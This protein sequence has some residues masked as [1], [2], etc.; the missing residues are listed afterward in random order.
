MIGA[1][2]ERGGILRCYERGRGRLARATVPKIAVVVRKA[3][4]GGHIA[5]GGRPVQPEPA[6]R[7]AGRRDGLHGARHRRAHRLP[8]QAG[9]DRG[10]RRA[11]RRATRA[12]PSSRPNGPP[13]R[14]PGRRRR[15]II[16]DDVIDPRDTR[17]TIINGIDFAWGSGPRV[18]AAGTG[19]H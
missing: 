13:S 5:M 6:R 2:A 3:Y 9:R 17:E 11:R 4:G 16:L 10:G 18:T 8:A 12:P 15:N 19:G 14:S 1:E 7:L